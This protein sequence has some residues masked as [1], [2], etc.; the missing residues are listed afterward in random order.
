M[1]ILK[2]PYIIQE[3]I[4]T[5]STDIRAI[6][7]GNKVIAAMKRKAKKQEIRANFHLGG[8]CEKY[9]MDYDSEQIAINAAKAVGA[10]I[11]AVDIL[12]GKTSSVIEVN[13]SPGLVGISKATKKDIP[14]LVAKSLFKKAKEYKEKE[15]GENY[16]NIL[17]ELDI[18][19]EKEIITNLNIKA[20][21]IKLPSIFTKI[22]D[23]NTKDEVT[24]LA[25]KG[26][27]T[28]KKLGG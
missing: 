12:E 24:I 28:I 17:K 13:L 6:V 16:N 25:K 23:F 5:D 27:L 4:D 15:K 11:C 19:K 3:F 18:N 26:K 8:I 1:D 20:E 7:A 2:Q 21:I 10:D 22:T 9:E 14:R